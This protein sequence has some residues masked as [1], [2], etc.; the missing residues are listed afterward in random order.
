MEHILY[1]KSILDL[2]LD[3]NLLLWCENIDCV[4]RTECCLTKYPSICVKSRIAPHR[5]VIS[6]A[7]RDTEPFLAD[8]MIVVLVVLSRKFMVEKAC[9]TLRELS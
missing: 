3:C 1:K 7:G 4:R 8:H 5:V 6:R 2:T 9:W